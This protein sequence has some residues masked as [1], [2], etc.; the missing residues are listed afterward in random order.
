MA[1]TPGTL[2]GWYALHDFRRIDWPRWNALSASDRRE[3]LQEASGYFRNAELISGHAEGSSALYRIV[4]HKADLMVLHLRPT[5]E[6][7][8][9]L[10]EDF[11]RTRLASYTTRP[12]SYL[13]VTELSLYEA[14]ARSGGVGDPAEL[15]KQEHV[16]KRLKF[17]IPDMPYVC[18][19]PMNKRRGE[20]VN[21]YTA[22]IDERRNMMRGHGATG[23]KYADQVTQLITGSMGLDD[24]EWG[25][26]LFAVDPLPIKKLVYEMR[27]DEVSAKYAEF[28]SFQVGIRLPAAKLTEVLGK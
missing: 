16:L 15:M 14:S 26:T 10:E 9:S 28:G 19:Y 24:W 2:E 7:L 12:Y 18:F 27:F 22:D 17:R 3:I 25:V 21:W 8:S 4:G 5:L 23:R 20:T 6:Q 13:S 1:E 11:A